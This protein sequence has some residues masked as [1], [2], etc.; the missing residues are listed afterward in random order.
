MFRF[1]AVSLF[2]AAAVLCTCQAQPPADQ[3]QGQTV[4]RYDDLNLSRERD[5]QQM[6]A[7]LNEAAS[8]A[9][10]GSPFLKGLQPG[11][12]HFVMSDYRRCREE[13]LEKAVASLRAPVVT[14]LYAQ[15]R[16]QTANRVA[17]R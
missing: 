16:G 17:G 8:Q 6:L 10:G 13:A 3:I 1:V 2:T 5:A 9:C 11:T 12:G 14:R 15:S 4:V 7:R